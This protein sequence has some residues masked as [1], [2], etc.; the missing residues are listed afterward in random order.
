MKTQI[1]RFLH[2]TVRK[3]RYSGTHTLNLFMEVEKMALKYKTG[4]DS[5]TKLR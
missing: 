5:L 2:E 3:Q 4:Y 1:S